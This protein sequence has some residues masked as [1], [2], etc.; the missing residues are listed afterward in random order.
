VQKFYR[1]LIK[2]QNFAEFVNDILR[3]KAQNDKLLGAGLQQLIEGFTVVHVIRK[4]YVR[5]IFFAVLGTLIRTVAAITHEVVNLIIPSKRVS[6]GQHDT[7][8]SVPYFF[9]LEAWRVA[10]EFSHALRLAAAHF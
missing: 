6:K 4:A 2:G 10:F 5:A 7:T 1:P 3:E 9:R 8:R